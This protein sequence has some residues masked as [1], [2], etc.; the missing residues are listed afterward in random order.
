MSIDILNMRRFDENKNA[1]DIAFPVLAVECEA[2]EISDKA[3]DSYERVV[4][5]L[6]SLGL[7]KKGI[8]RTLN[9]TESFIQNVFEVLKARNLVIDAYAKPW[10]LTEEGKK[11]LID[12]NKEIIITNEK[13]Y[14]YLFINSLKKELLPYFFKGNIEKVSLY[15][16]EHLPLKLNI[17]KDEK[18][19]FEITDIK[20][21]KL[22]QAYKAYFRLKKQNQQHENIEDIQETIESIDLFADLDS[23][24]EEII[25]HNDD[26]TDVLHDF[27]DNLSS[28]KYVT[29]TPNDVFVRKLNKPALKLYL[30]M[31]IIID[32]NSPGGYKVESP[33]NDFNGADNEFFLRQIQWCELS[34]KV[35]VYENHNN[36][37]IKDFLEN[38]IWKI[39][40][41]FKP[42]AK[43]LDVYLLENLPLIKSHPSKFSAI[44]DDMERIYPL[45]Q[46]PDSILKKENCISSISRRIVEV[47]FNS[48]FKKLGPR[49]LKKIQK[50]A[51][52]EL[53]L[54]GVDRFINI[55]C[56]RTKLNYLSFNELSC[57]RI[58][59]IIANLTTSHG[60]SIEE[61]FINIL[62]INFYYDDEIIQNL[63]SQEKID[64]IYENIKKLNH[65]RIKVSHAVEEKLTDDDYTFYIE[66]IFKLV[67]TLMQAFVK[68]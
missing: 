47:L 19:T 64:L 3:L 62:V 25:D 4:M 35:F 5:K 22:K 37:N 55:L 57:R 59:S 17:N 42:E 30:R 67:N 54:Y 20:I 38:E 11:F 46:H 31:R 66:N 21:S 53:D 8:A 12:S 28:D 51:F 40:R 39:S 23:F 15:K 56:K 36:T 9:A 24:D 49:N 63:L 2:S 41:N 58:K 60:N 44:Y 34:Q 61:K 50:E 43:V 13:Q 16:G 45:I 18:N 1:I 10:K 48:F 29:N 32:P 52:E 26:E 65:I 7:S 14:G 27:K 33:F 68:D 6:I